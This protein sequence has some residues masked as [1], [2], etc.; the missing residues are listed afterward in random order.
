MSNIDV[1]SDSSEFPW[2][3]L[4][5]DVV[6]TYGIGDITV[7]AL[8]GVSLG[9]RRGEYVAVMGAS[10]GGKS[11]LMNIIGCLD[12]PTSGRYLLD[13]VD[14]SRLRE[15]NLAEIRNRLVGFVF[16]SFNLV[17]RTSA[18][19]N[20]ELPLVYAG[21]KR[22]ERLE[23]ALHALDVVGLADRAHHLPT[24]LSGGQ[25]QRVAIARAICT[26]PAIILAD[27]PT[28]ALDSHSS[29]GVLE[30][31]DRL[32]DEGRTVVLI[33][34]DA[35]VATHAHHQL[36][37]RD[38]RIVEETWSGTSGRPKVAELVR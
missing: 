29:A 35:D 33:T 12:E 27:E 37:M 15:W 31:F 1:S 9:I 18:L 17:P 19:A 28:G 2:V 24:E 3:I 10:G 32:N 25:Q 4:L 14:V 13:G 30:I 22:K 6:K 38:G 34:H 26:D 8:D 23:R 16:Q 21:V 5:K 20:V 7:R 36:R 11:T